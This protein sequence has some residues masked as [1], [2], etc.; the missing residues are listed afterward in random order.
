MNKMTQPFDSGVDEGGIFII[1]T[2]F[3]HDGNRIVT[4]NYQTLQRAQEIER[5][6]LKAIKQLINRGTTP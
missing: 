6:L 5:E 1:T 4:K 2:D 3:D